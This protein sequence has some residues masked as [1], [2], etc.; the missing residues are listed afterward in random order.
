MPG[1]RPC[2]RSIATS[3]LVLHMAS[4]HSWRSE[5]LAPAQLVPAEHP[6]VVRV[7]RSDGSI[8]ILRHPTV[9]ND[10]MFGIG[11]DSAEARL[12]LQDVREVEVR[13]FSAGKTAGLVLGVAGGAALAVGAA[14]LIWL[15]SCDGPCFD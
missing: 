13:R 7:T 9:R 3:L 2:H 4:C 1:P 15:S 14:F 5:A 10:S 6:E 12:A 11:P 8:L